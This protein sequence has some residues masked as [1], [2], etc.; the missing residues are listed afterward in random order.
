M[1]GNKVDQTSLIEHNGNNTGTEMNYA[2]KV[3]IEYGDPNFSPECTF[4]CGICYEDFDTKDPN[5]KVKMLDKCNH[6]FCSQC[7]QDYY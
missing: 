4:K 6:T 1:E 5:F 2:Q 7:F 3:D